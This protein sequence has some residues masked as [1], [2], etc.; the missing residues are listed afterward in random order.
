MRALPIQK[1]NLGNEFVLV[2]PVAEKQCAMIG[3]IR[4]MFEDF[5]N[6]ACISSDEDASANVIFAEAAL[7]IGWKLEFIDRCTGTALILYFRNIS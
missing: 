6:F 1:D 4:M 3:P 2:G 7:A 5:E